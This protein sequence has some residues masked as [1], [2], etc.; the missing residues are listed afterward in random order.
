MTAELA[1]PLRQEATDF[2]ASARLSIPSNAN[3]TASPFIR[4]L[5]VLDDQA[6]AVWAEQVLAL[7]AHWTRRDEHLPFYTLGLAAYLD[8]VR[9]DPQLGGK[10]AYHVA[11]LRQ[12]SNKLITA[13]FDPLLDRCCQALAESTGQPALCAGEP[14]ALPGFHIHL[15]HPLFGQDVAS[16]HVDLQ[17]KQV[18]GV[19]QPHPDEVLTLTLALSLPAGAGLRLWVGDEPLFHAYQLGHLVLHNGLTPHQAVLH[20]S[21]GMVPR[22]MLQCH[23]LLR[24]GAWVLYW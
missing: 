23:G 11:A 17:F 3:V 12:E 13:H 9:D 16:R 21:G 14:A 4:S 20:P 8:A 10:R 7:R 6:C 15:P 22:I 2:V 5:P 24:E 19:S 18:F 1:R